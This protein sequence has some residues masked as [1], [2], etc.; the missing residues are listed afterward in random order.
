MKDFTFN[1]FKKSCPTL[2]D[3]YADYK[4]IPFEIVAGPCRVESKEQIEAAAQSMVGYGIERLRAGCFKPTTFP[5]DPQGGGL[6][7]AAILKEV[8]DKY[9]LMSVSEVMTQEQAEEGTKYFDVAQIGARNMQNFDLLKS[10]GSKYREVVVKRHPGASLRDMCG[11][12]EWVAAHGDTEVTVC[13]RGIV[14]PHTHAAEARWI[15]DFSFIVAIKEL[16]PGI[17]VMFDASHSAGL[18]WKVEPF[19]KAGVA[20]GADSIM[21][22]A[23]PNPRHSVSDKDQAISLSELGPLVKNLREISDILR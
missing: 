5:G 16:M 11:A 13:E 10:L 7:S 15:P 4:R 23:H 9:N 20:A 6:K 8:A 2:Y 17:K 21:I 12:L 19:A 1:D 18:Y 22:E 3:K 14:A